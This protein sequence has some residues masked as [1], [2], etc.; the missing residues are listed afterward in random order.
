MPKLSVTIVAQDEETDIAECVASAAWADEVVVVDGGSRDRTVELAERAGARVIRQ[1]WMGYAA[2]KNFAIERATHDWVFSLDADERVTPD[3]REEI[4]R[5]LGTASPRDGYYVPRRSYFLGQWMRHGGW[6]PDYN[7]RLFRRD[8]GRF[9]PREVHECVD[10]A[11][12]VGYLTAPIDHYTYRTLSE[13][14]QRMDRYSSLAATELLK[15]GSRPG[16]TDVVVR[17]ALTFAR[18]FVAKAGFRDGMR[19]LLL[20]GCYASYTFFK[21][22]KAWEAARASGRAS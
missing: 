2:Q 1:P 15:R 21:Y 5:V 22:A 9:R 17:P 6:Y 3:L 14:A 4:A 20:A 7:L 13:Y 19:G 18:M 11:G 8:K 10:V 16:W 12:S